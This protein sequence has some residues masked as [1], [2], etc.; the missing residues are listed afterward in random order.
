MD[1]LVIRPMDFDDVAEVLRIER[2]LFPAPWSRE[3]FLMEVCSPH[4]S[5]SFVAEVAG[6]VVGYLVAWFVREEVHLVNIAVARAR[7]GRG[8]GSALMNHLLCLA[9]R[10]GRTSVTLEVR[11]SNVTARRF[12]RSF[13]FRDVGIRRRYYSDNG[14]DAVIMVLDLK[15]G[16]QGRGR[17][18]RA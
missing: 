6:E 16:S 17:E 15:G 12:Y 2:D 8:V 7:Q 14:E 18:E 10:E 4:V 11:V 1:E 5:R 13:C 3:S 9:R